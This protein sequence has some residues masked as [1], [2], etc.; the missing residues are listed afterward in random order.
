MCGGKESWERDEKG[1]VGERKAEW[2]EGGGWREGRRGGDL[3]EKHMDIRCPIANVII[4]W[5]ISFWSNDLL[6]EARL[7]CRSS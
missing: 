6:G 1:R 4:S 2:D 3:G 7:G 5:N